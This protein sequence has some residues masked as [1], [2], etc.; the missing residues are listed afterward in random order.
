M[1]LTLD[2]I[3]KALFIENEDWSSMDLTKVGLLKDELEGRGIECRV[4]ERASGKKEEVFAAVQEAQIIAFASTFVYK[5]QVKGLGDLLS[6]VK[7]PKI[8]I[9]Y[10]MSQS[11]LRENIEEIWSVPELVKFAHHRVFELAR[12]L[13]ESDDFVSEIDMNEYIKE[14]KLSEEERIKRNKGFKKTGAKVII[15]K[16]QAV[17]PEWSKLVEGDIVDELDCSSIDNCPEAGIWVMGLT[18]PVKL[19]NDSGYDEWEFKDPNCF[20]L[21]RE[22]FLRGRR[23]KDNYLELEHLIGE[24]IGK[25]TGKEKMNG[26][27]LWDFCDRLCKTLNLERRGNRHYFERRLNEHRSRFHYFKDPYV[28]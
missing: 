19:L 17:G 10:A 25:C 23:H 2:G 20:A 12:A 11:S 8:I 26:T 16:I 7:E 15:K 6:L 5:S 28:H 4:I 18:E 22:F 3:T 21:A 9:G 1:K 27:E 13:P 24:Y 14:F